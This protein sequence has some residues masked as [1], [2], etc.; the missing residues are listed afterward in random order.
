[1][2]ER[3]VVPVPFQIGTVN[4]YRS[5]RTLVDPGPD[6]DEAWETLEAGLAEADL[7]P[8]DVEQVLITHPHPDHFGV[9][10]RFRDRGAEV[11]A[12]PVGGDII[13]AFAD[14]LAH[15]Q[16]H[17]GPLLVRHGVDPDLAET[18]VELPE[19]YLEF[20]PDTP[21]DRRV[22]DGE[23]IAVDDAAVRAEAVAGHA[24]GELIYTFEGDDGEAAIVGDHVLDPI[25]PNPFLQ[26]PTETGGPRPRVLPAYNR[27][28]DRLADRGFVRLLPGHRAVIEEP[29]HRIR[30]LRRFH[31]H[32]TE[33]VYDILDEPMSA[34]AVMR[35]LFGHLP[36]TEVFPGMSEAIGHLDVLEE[37]GEVVRTG[38][39]PVRYERTPGQY[40]GG[41]SS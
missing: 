39:A 10:G 30:Q 29:T 15:E 17:L 35:E 7:T 11:V 32:R 13:E 20:A 3:M 27:S 2:F 21:V 16:R 36:A 34:A 33:Q 4:C 9:A 6:S 38:D 41:R 31:E 28:L 8:G 12:S 22:G 1:M 14:R 25:T 37:R 5:G 40:D 24:P 26:P 23:R 19:V 18:V